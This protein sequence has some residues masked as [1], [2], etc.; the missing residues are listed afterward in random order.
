[1]TPQPQLLEAIRSLE[2]LPKR[3]AGKVNPVPKAYDP[4]IHT[5]LLHLR[6]L[7]DSDPSPITPAGFAT[8]FC[9]VHRH[10]PS[11]RVTLILLSTLVVPVEVF[12]SLADAVEAGDHPGRSASPHGLSPPRR[13]P[14]K[15]LKTKHNIGASSSTGQRGYSLS[16]SRSVWTEEGRAK[17]GG[18]AGAGGLLGGLSRER[19]RSC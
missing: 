14:S 3:R 6:A 15:R 5:L 2:A 12:S 11:P 13:P 19:M 4:S 18:R 17:E 7:L 8:A 16:P 1:M 9:H 10:L